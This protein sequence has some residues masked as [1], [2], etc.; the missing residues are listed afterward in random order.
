MRWEKNTV[1]NLVVGRKLI[2]YCEFSRDVCS[3]AI[4]SNNE[5]IG[6]LWAKIIR[7]PKIS[8]LERHAT[9]PV[10]QWLTGF[11][12]K[13]MAVLQERPP[14]A[15]AVWISPVQG[16]QVY[17]GNARCSDIFLSNWK[18]RCRNIRLSSNCLTA[19]GPDCAS[20]TSKMQ[21]GLTSKSFWR[22]IFLLWIS[23][24]RQRK[25]GF[26]NSRKSSALS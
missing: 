19:P 6:A 2:L 9:K 24:S 15:D 13:I 14:M 7:L 8:F 22:I 18:K 26:G 25:S 4:L 10:S 17:H 16:I 3:H 12:L 23:P 1:H 21:S 11:L 20:V 5:I